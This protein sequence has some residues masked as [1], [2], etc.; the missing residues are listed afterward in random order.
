MAIYV[1]CDIHGCFNEFRQM[2]HLIEFGPKDELI[3]AGDFI[4]RGDQTANILYWLEDAPDNVVLLRGNHEEEYL[5]YI[6]LMKI[7]STKSK[8][9][10]LPYS[11]QDSVE[12]YSLTQMVASKTGIIFDHY[13]TIRY[14]IESDGFTLLDLSRFEALFQDLPYYTRRSA[15]G[16]DYIIVHA[17][18]PRQV[19]EDEEKFRYYCLYARDEAYLEGGQPHH[20]VIAGHTPTLAD[21]QM[22]YTGGNAFFYCDEKT[23]RRFYDIDCGCVFRERYPGGKLA[24]IRLGD[25]KIFYI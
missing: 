23:H 17:G 13:H 12:L 1:M 16:R 21:S 8:K 10:L 9:E 19:P 14:L 11:Y 5:H 25:E 3:L 22:M 2:L 6:D 20:T 4:D 24:C 15:G 7:V 18:F